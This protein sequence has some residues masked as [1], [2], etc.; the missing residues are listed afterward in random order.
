MAGVKVKNIKKVYPGGVVAVHNASLEIDDHEF[1]VLVGPSGC[2]KST[3]LRLVSD[4][5]QPTSGKVIVT[6]KAHAQLARIT[7]SILCLKSRCCCP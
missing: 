3:I 7:W 6:G 2:G 5:H 1:V 4:I